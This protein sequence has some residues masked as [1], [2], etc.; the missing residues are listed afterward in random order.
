[1]LLDDR[2]YCVGRAIENNNDKDEIGDKVWEMT[3]SEPDSKWSEVA[4]MNDK[5]EV[6]GAVIFKNCLMI[7][8]GDDDGDNDLSSSKVF[9]PQLAKYYCNESSSMGKCTG[10]V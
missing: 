1:M 8:G 2:I 5:R 7:A 9:I 10:R 3:L 4:S 6:M